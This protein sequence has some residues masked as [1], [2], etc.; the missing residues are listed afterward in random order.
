MDSSLYRSLNK[1]SSPL[2]IQFLESPTLILLKDLQ[3]KY[4]KN[5][6]YEILKELTKILFKNKNSLW[7]SILFLLLYR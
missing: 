5:T 6:L 7:K 1:V 3:G 4:N 2:P